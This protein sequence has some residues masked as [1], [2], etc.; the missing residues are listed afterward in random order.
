MYEQEDSCIKQEDLMTGYMVYPK[1]DNIIRFRLHKAVAEKNNKHNA[2]VKKK[3]F[4]IVMNQ[5]KHTD[6]FRSKWPD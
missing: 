3:P 1:Y 2:F 4:L 6:Q 5:E